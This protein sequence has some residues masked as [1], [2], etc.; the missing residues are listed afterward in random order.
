MSLDRSPTWAVVRLTVRLIRRSTLLIAVA[1]AVY[2]AVEVQVMEATYPDAASRAALEAFGDFPALRIM[3]GVPYSVETGALVAWDAGWLMSLIAGVW[4]ITTTSRLLRGDEEEGRTEFV[5][6]GLLRSAQVLVCQAVVLVGAACALGLGVAVGS[7][8]GGAPLAGGLLFGAAIAGFSTAFIG[9]TAVGAQVFASRTRVLGVSATL[10]GA[11]LVLRMTANSADSRAWLA[12]LTP[13]GWIDQLKPFG[14]N[15]V[16]VLVVPVAVVAGLVACAV[17]LR[18]RRDSQAG[19]VAERGERQTRAWGLTSPLAFA[20][21]ANLGTLIGWAVG[22]TVWSLI[23]GVL[24]PS[25]NDFIESDPAYQQ[26]LATMGMDVTDLTNGFVAMLATIVGVAL[27]VF[28]AWRIG[29]ARAEE[30]SARLE[31]IV[32]R[33]VLRR[34]WLAGHIL[35][36]GVSVL[37]LAIISGAATWVGAAAAGSDLT[38]SD[39]LAAVLNTVP[40]VVVFGGLA[41]LVLG[42]APRATVGLVASAAVLAYVLQIVGPALDWPEAVVAVSPFRH[43]ALV[44]VESFEPGSTAVLLVIGVVAAVIGTVMF[45]RRDLVGA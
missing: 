36:M 7:V 35:L 8:V 12:W 19:L 24:V 6:V 18:V 3:Q 33:P 22:L 45:E 1:Y 4:V 21:R 10:L 23:A 29:A 38:V 43:L 42:L 32:T 31:L 27:A 37:L 34:R 28:A 41:V 2:A 15:R 25:M 5:L 17:G 13:F 44:P 39:S 9:L 20:W 16:V 14:A 30:A 26:I 11:A 40:A